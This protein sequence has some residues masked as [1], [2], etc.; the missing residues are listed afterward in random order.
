MLERILSLGASGL[1]GH[2]PSALSALLLAWVLLAY[3][4][5]A[6][7]LALIDLRSHLLPDALVFPLYWKL[8]LPLLV[9]NFL[10]GAGLAGLGRILAGA[11]L[12]GA[13]YWLTRLLSGRGLGLGDVKLAPLLGALAV[14]FSWWNLLWA[15]L[16]IYLLAG[17]VAG[18]LLL[19]GRIRPSSHLAFG[20]Y[21]LLGA[22]LALLFPAS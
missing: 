12:M 4:Y 16:L 10:E 5:W 19:T 13:F 20:P 15:N 8:G 6:Y 1:A 18:F 21:M 22:G 14:Y 11:G 17:L 3:S 2:L 9:A 7:W